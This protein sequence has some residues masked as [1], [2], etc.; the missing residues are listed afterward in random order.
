MLGIANPDVKGEYQNMF[1]KKG[2]LIDDPDEKEQI[3]NQKQYLSNEKWQADRYALPFS[4]YAPVDLT[5]GNVFNTFRMS[6]GDFD[7]TQMFHLT[8]NE[9]L[10]Y[11]ILFTIVLIISNVI[12]LNFI[13]AEAS[14]SYK[15]VM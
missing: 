14:E 1:I 2:Y 10:I 8:A 5:V 11:W 7:F 6:L 13:I 12:F 3:H 9:G 4:E 15:R